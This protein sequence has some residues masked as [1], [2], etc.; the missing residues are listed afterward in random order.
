[1][2]TLPFG[3]GR[4]WLK[5]PAVKAPSPENKAEAVLYTIA[6]DYMYT[7]RAVH[8]L[9]PIFQIWA[10]VVG[11]PPPIN[12]IS[13]IER[14]PVK[15]SVTTLSDSVAC[16]RGVKRPY[17][18]EKDG[19]SILIYVL[20]PAV[21]LVRDTNMVCLA[22]AAKLGNVAL[23][24]QVRPVKEVDLQPDRNPLHQ[25][26]ITRL[27]FVPGESTNPVLPQRH[28]DRYDTRLW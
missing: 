4:H 16:F 27:E 9:S 14:S 21:T 19:S 23:T 3:N 2:T 11:E 26:V 17:T 20:N 15:V 25:G 6:D 5:P 12:N 18:D 22:K 1:M 13:R 24:V 7:L 28:G 10:H 8:R